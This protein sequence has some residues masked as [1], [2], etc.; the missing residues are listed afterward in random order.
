M[1]TEVLSHPDL[2]LQAKQAHLFPELNK[3]LLSIGTFYHDGC[4]ATFN[5]KSVHIKNKQSGNIIMRVTR[6]IRTNLYM[7]NLTQ[8]KELVTES[9]TPDEYY[10]G[11]AYECKSKSTL[12]DYHH[13][14]CWSPTHSGW[15]KAIT[16]NF[17]TSWP[18]L[19]LEMV[20][21][22]LT[23]KKINRTWT[24]PAT[25]KGPHINTRKGHAF[26]SRSRTIP[27]PTIQAVRKYQY[28]LLQDSGS[29]S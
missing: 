14:S 13:I 10:A 6:D 25:A 20:H 11:S 4:E 22:H 15:V 21:K 9:T 12:V 27:V 16:K 29:F 1:H 24:P 7:L 19:S 28:Y 18:G 17:F 2:P 8:K 3:A 26:I 5:Y 23:R